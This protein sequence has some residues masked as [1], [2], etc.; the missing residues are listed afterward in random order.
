MPIYYFPAPPLFLVVAYVDARVDDW[1]GVAFWVA[2]ALI[3]A[4]FMLAAK[5]KKNPLPRGVVIEIGV[6]TIL[7]LAVLI[8][9]L[10]FGYEG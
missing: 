4:A 6:L 5:L 9:R 7:S 1:Y 3:N 8:V 2:A 10:I